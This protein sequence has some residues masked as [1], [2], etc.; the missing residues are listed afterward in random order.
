MTDDDARRIVRELQA[1]CRIPVDGIVGPE[2]EEAVRA[3]RLEEYEREAMLIAKYPPLRFNA[4]GKLLRPR[5][6]D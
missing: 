2:T 5:S 3:I 4:D 6:R 1:R